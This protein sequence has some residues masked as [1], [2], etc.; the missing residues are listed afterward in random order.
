MARKPPERETERTSLTAPR[1]RDLTPPAGGQAI[2][3]FHD[4]PKQLC[5]RV[6]P[7][8]AKSFVF[9]G[10]LNKTP[11]RVTIGSTDVWT[12]GDA[13]T[14]ARRLQTL[15]DRG[16]DPRQEKADK[17]APNNPAILDTW[18]MLLASTDCS[19]SSDPPNS[20]PNQPPSS[21]SA[22]CAGWPRSM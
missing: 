20:Q 16:V 14:E 11:L 10:K 3:V 1:I 4:D 7:A 2:Y 6:T 5:V 13:R 15:V 9:A 22:F 18:A 19:S 12:I 21:A 8:G 17:L